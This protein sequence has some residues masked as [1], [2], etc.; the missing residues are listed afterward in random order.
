MSPSPP[1]K[2]VDVAP[3]SSGAGGRIALGVA[4]LICAIGLALIPWAVA[5]QSPSDLPA[6]PGVDRVAATCV[7]CHPA[8]IFTE[9]RMTEDEW[10]EILDRMVG[11][12]VK[13]TDADRSVIL[14][15]LST[16]LGPES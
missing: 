13:I 14:E 12:G 6:G 7:A 10:S 15:Y 3:S 8:A 16:T 2:S 5:A 1:D 9:R 11:I 4:G